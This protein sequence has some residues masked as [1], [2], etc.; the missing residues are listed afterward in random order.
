MISSVF[1]LS[2]NFQAF[3]MLCLQII[4]RVSNFSCDGCCR[5]GGW[6]TEINLRF[7]TAHASDE[8]PIHR[9]ESALTRTQQPAVTT[10][11]STASNYADSATCIVEDLN[12]PI[13]HSLVKNLHTGRRDN[14]T[15]E[16][17]DSTS[18]QNPRG[19]FKVF[20]TPICA[21]ANEDFINGQAFHLFERLHMIY[22]GM[23]SHLRTDI[24]HINFDDFFISGINWF[25][26]IEWST[27]FC[28]GLKKSNR[29]FIRHKQ[30]TFR[31]N[32]RRHIREDD[33]FMHWQ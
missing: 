24:R 27:C 33:T 14:R 21:S 23:T 19:D 9:C 28:F 3:P 11:T 18:F 20:I 1:K 8:V 29:G 13:L 15:R 6:A 25:D 10:N 17:T 26:D 7:R 22:V 2:S 30:A 32:L 12:Q 16:W 31:T 5:G 4:S